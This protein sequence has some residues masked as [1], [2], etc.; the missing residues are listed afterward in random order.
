MNENAIYFKEWLK[1]KPSDFRIVNMLALSENKEF[2]GNLSD[3]CKKFSLSSQD[4]NK[5]RI[6]KSIE[7]LEEN[8]F[9]TV[10][11][12]GRTYTLNVVPKETKIQVEK[13][14]IE[15]ILTTDFSE[16]VSKEA[17]I[18]C[19]LWLMNNTEAIITDS[20]IAAD[21]DCCIDTI[22]KAKNVLQRDFNLINKNSITEKS[23]N[24]FVRKGQQIDVNAWIGK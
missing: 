23:K 5:K 1:L 22:T 10:N 11:K 7:L 3:L 8:S 4:N 12:S 13:C 2:K 19:L 9:I 15:T 14:W 17:V 6:K 20:S 18:K 16:S 21:L 24:R